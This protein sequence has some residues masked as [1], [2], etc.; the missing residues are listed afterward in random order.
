MRRAVSTAVRR[1]FFAFAA[2]LAVAGTQGPAWAQSDLRPN[3]T[4][5]GKDYF[6]G[7][8]PASAMDMV[9]L[10]P[11]F[12]LVEGDVT[13]RGYSGAVGNVVIDGQPPASKQ[14]KL[15]DILKRIPADSVERIELVRP[16]AAG[17]DMLGYPLL[18]NVVR[19]S[20]NAPRMRV[21]GEVAVFRHGVIA[22]KA[23][24]EIS[25]GSTDVLDLS[26]A[27]WRA[28]AE[29]FMGFGRRDRIS[30]SGTPLQLSH[31]EQ[32]KYDEIWTVMAGYRQPLLGG[33]INLHALYKDQ[34]GIDYI[35]EQRRLPTTV[36]FNGGDKEFRPAM[37]F[38]AEYD[39][40]LWKDAENQLI[41]IRR[42]RREKT[43][44]FSDQTGPV[45]ASLKD[46]HWSETVLRDMVRQRSTHFTFEAG[47]EAAINTLNNKNAL[48]SNNTPVFLPAANVLIK[49]K[50]AEFFGNLI[51]SFNPSLSL[52]TG[53]RYEMSEFSQKG[54]SNLEKSL[55]Y[56]KP[57][58][59]LTWQATKDD[60]L[61]FLYEREAGQLDFTNFVSFVMVSIASVTSGNKNQVPSTLWRKE[62]AWEHRF[63]N[64]GSMV[65]TGRRE[66]ISDVLD[67]VV[68]TENGTTYDAPGNVGD[69]FREELQL[70][71]I[72]P[73]DWTGVPG[74]TLQGTGL[75]RVSGVKDPANGFGRRIS[76]DAPEEGK[77]SLTHDIPAWNLR[78]GATYKHDIEKNQ[79]RYNEIRG[80]HLY[81]RVDAF[82]EYKPAAEWLVRLFGRNLTDT[83]DY[84]SRTTYL[85]GGI[86]GLVPVDYVEQRPLTF[87]PGFG[88]NIQKT[89]GS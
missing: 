22:P 1:L 55:A 32:P 21:E 25:I 69:G 6:A 39:H 59:L 82:V 56:L 53:L 85:G 49:E 40:D 50:R 11:G 58:A 63:G 19:K 30:G 2:V 77:I 46:A 83:P 28:P 14:D 23:A 72:L 27:A 38:N 42:D 3:V 54:D 13:V 44:N 7:A 48:T 34:R 60:E 86:R 18:V 47:A 17:M 41:A 87:G 52:E 33:K 29:D 67:R 8:Q 73:L 62:V 5:Y 79:L 37:E 45:V 16:G 71:M 10:L 4:G 76:N 80:D 81:S 61:R 36:T 88:I 43:I 84:R 15:E 31:Y 68:L 66:E 26:V 24:A 75:Y 74:F 57:R 20:N 51:T 64:S 65:L 70:D 78:W 12:R 35:L 89:F 9:T